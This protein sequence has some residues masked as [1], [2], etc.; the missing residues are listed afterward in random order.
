MTDN[1]IG[2]TTERFTPQAVSDGAI[3]AQRDA[4]FNLSQA[5]MGLMEKGSLSNNSGNLDGSGN[6]TNGQLDLSGDIY[7]TTQNTTGADNIAQPGGEKVFKHPAASTPDKNDR[8]N[9]AESGDNSPKVL[10]HPAH[11][12]HGSHAGSRLNRS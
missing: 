5:A 1:Q 8:P 12:S 2:A 6:L 4:G 9:V 10:K 3:T 7:K 11:S